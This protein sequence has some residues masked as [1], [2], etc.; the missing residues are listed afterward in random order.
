MSK[1]EKTLGVVAVVIAVLGAV[2]TILRIPEA[3]TI[4]AALVVLYG[5]F[6]LA[7]LLREARRQKRSIE[8]LRESGRLTRVAID[9]TRHDLAASGNSVLESVRQIR[10]EVQVQSRHSERQHASLNSTVAG[11]GDRIDAAS[12]SL[13]A[14]ITAQIKGYGRDNQLVVQE[15]AENA[16][17]RLIQAEE[18]INEQ[19]DL[20][21]RQVRYQ[22]VKE[23]KAIIAEITKNE[24]QIEHS[25]SSASENI[26]I[27]QQV[28]MQKLLAHQDGLRHVVDLVRGSVSDLDDSVSAA[29]ITLNDMERLLGRAARSDQLESVVIALASQQDEV[30]KL[31]MGLTT[32]QGALPS[33]VTLDAVA[34]VGVAVDAMESEIKLLIDNS[35]ALTENV[36]GLSQHAS[37]EAKRTAR[38]SPWSMVTIGERKDALNDHDGGFSQVRSLDI[39]STVAGH[40]NALRR[41]QST[42][43][44][45]RLSQAIS[46]GD[47]RRMLSAL[48][49]QIGMKDVK[50]EFVLDVEAYDVGVS[51]R[52]QMVRLM[53][54]KER[55]HSLDCTIS[56]REND[57]MRDR[58]FAEG[59]DIPT[60]RLLF[61]DLPT[62]E[63]SPEPD[64]IIKPM[65]GESSRGV[66]YVRP[67][68]CLM[69][70]KTRNVYPNFPEAVAEYERWTRANRDPRW[71]GERAVLDENG[72]PARD[73][74]VF[75]FYGKVGL[76]REIVRFQD[77]VSGTLAVAYDENGRRVAYRDSDDPDHYAD[78]PEGIDALAT[79]ISLASPVPFLRVDF[80]AGADGPVLGEITPHPG[81]IYAG[82]AYDD[83][84]RRLGRMFLEAEA[85]LAV[86][87]LNCKDFGDY[88]RAYG[89]DP[90]ANG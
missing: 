19:M 51:F 38:H 3:G 45:V 73:I 24:L 39:E 67:D 12:S 74:K 70:L 58:A 89:I 61:H 33:V 88:F 63:V 7:Q 44:E 42:L 13:D 90:F 40:K 59:F 54:L 2:L 66:F 79:R 53:H 10:D 20:R 17:S 78:I 50:Q 5:L 60:P 26:Q 86:D 9:D 43:Q 82:D 1:L 52:A 49:A 30:E 85:R 75:M 18:R 29:S 35:R 55:L 28:A 11:L 34:E 23:R 16:T 83:I 48:Y 25:I 72:V 36:L 22:V 27:Y 64:S 41:L 31:S 77:G 62:S 4:A 71:I 14:T 47:R 81:G 68:S 56:P 8:L 32:L 80:L 15:N 76:Y 6:L 87:L 46:E 65:V 69:S 21:A 84:D 57:K 37:G